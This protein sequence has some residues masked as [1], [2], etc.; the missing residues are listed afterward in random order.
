MLRSDE[1]FVDIGASLGQS[2]RFASQVMKPGSQIVSVEADLFRFEE[3]KR[4]CAA[5]QEGP[6]LTPKMRDAMR[7]LGV[8]SWL[9]TRLPAIFVPLISYQQRHPL[10]LSFEAA[11]QPPTATELLCVLKSPALNP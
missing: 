4:N 5:W 6:G 8:A 3:L 2:P 7:R 11:R 1:S 10:R 9:G